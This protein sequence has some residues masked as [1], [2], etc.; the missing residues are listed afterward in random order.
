MLQRVEEARFADRGDL[1]HSGRARPPL[2]ASSGSTA[3]R[4][5]RINREFVAQRAGAGR[6]IDRFRRSCTVVS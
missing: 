4:A 3:F 2:N 5:Y 1:R 6:E